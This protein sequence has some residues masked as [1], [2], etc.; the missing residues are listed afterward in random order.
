[1]HLIRFTTYIRFTSYIREVLRCRTFNKVYVV[2]LRRFLPCIWDKV[3]AVHS[4][5]DYLSWILS[6]TSKQINQSKIVVEHQSLCFLPI[7]A[8]FIQLVYIIE[9]LLVCGEVIREP[10][11]VRCSDA[12]S[13]SGRKVD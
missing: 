4:G 7:N 9:Q 10:F 8:L 13:C 11:I 5:E 3:S 1:M 12:V 2:H 6:S